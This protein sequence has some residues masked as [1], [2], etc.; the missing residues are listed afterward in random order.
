MNYVVK[1]VDESGGSAC[2]GARGIQEISVISS[3]F[4]CEPKI[5]IFKKKSLKKIK[6]PSG[7]SEEKDW[8][9]ECPQ[10]ARLEDDCSMGP[11]V[12]WQ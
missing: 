4:G 6:D 10:V 1:D 3:Q 2:V 11:G 9:Q 8:G 7:C 5:A 12:R